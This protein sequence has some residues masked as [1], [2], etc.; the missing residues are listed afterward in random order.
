M[1]ATEFL[2]VHLEELAIKFPSV[3][4]KYGY[5]S[6]IETH[7]V[8]L[9]PLIEYKTNKDLDN[10]WIPV[11]LQFMEK[12]QYE[13]I[14][15]ISSDSTLSISSE[16]ILFEFNPNACTE[17][18]VISELFA[19]LTKF[20]LTYSFSTQVPD[21]IIMP[22]F[23]DAVLELPLEELKDETHFDYSCLAAA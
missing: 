17:E 23:F 6:I 4:I 3:H 15:F 19:P 11:S 9:L 18:H 10:S 7:I 16:H 13:E 1:T 2:K 22:F 5:N 8:E 14:A 21:G 12:F 20:A